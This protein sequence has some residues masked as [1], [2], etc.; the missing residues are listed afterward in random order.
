[1]R[2][3]KGMPANPEDRCEW[4]GEVF[5]GETVDEQYEDYRRHMARRDRDS[6]HVNHNP[7]SDQW[8]KAYNSIQAAK[9]KK[10]AEPEF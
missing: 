8:T 7:G 2:T 4:C 10:K 5:K 3:S 6:K 1:M 9:E